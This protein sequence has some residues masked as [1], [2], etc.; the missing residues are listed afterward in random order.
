[1]PG[2][3]ARRMPARIILPGRWFAPRASCEGDG[4]QDMIDDRARQWIDPWIARLAR[5]LVRLGISAN[6]VT[7]AGLAFGLAAAGAIAAGAFLSGLVL[8]LVSR[9]ADGL[10]GAVARMTQRTDLG[11]YLDIL[12]DFIFY[13]A[14]PLAFVAA[15]PAA[16]GL[17]GAALL[18]SF[19]VNGS[20]FLAFA[21]IE[22]RRDQAGV[23]AGPKALYF[24]K[25]LA[26]AG[27][28]LAFFI[29][30]CLWPG[31]FVPLALA[32]T[33]LCLVTAAAR[34]VDAARR[35]RDG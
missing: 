12:F 23:R 27:E 4:E 35:F 11:G 31:S 29:A 33:L 3:A 24:S 2:I 6:A 8:L 18:F 15:D 9:L 28:T 30:F 34:L 26:E 20:S 14:I 1:M 10:D 22:A 21:A 16:N 32:F 13:G 19:Y 5:P 7:V 25:G 17:A